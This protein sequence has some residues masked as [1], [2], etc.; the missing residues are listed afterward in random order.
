M[1]AAIARHNAIHTMSHALA[2]IQ[3]KITGMGC[4]IS[5][6]KARTIFFF[7]WGGGGQNLKF[8]SGGSEK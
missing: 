4:D 3:N 1:R 5:Y 8:Q 7:F 6:T 2:L